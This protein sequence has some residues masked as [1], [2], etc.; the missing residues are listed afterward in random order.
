MFIQTDYSGYGQDDQQKI[1]GRFLIM[2]Q[3]P[4]MEGLKQPI[5]CLVR[6][7]KMSQCG[8][9]MMGKVRIKGQSFT[10][11]GSYG[12]DGLTKDMPQEI[13]DLGVELPQE[14][15]EMWNKGGGHNSA[16]NEAGSIKAWALATFPQ[17][18][19]R[20]RRW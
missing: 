2:M 13:Y 17:K 16:G 8:H 7:C 3:P 10:V 4:G 19:R 9:W 18:T 15:H 12:A 5:K 6:Y 14:L 11:S 1:G 20:S